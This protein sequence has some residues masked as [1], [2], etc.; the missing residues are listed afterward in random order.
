VGALQLGSCALDH[1]PL[2]DDNLPA[3]VKPTQ[4]DRLLS[5]QEVQKIWH[6]A[7][8]E[9]GRLIKICQL[10]GMRRSEVA[11]IRGDWIQADTLVVPAINATNSWLYSQTRRSANPY[12]ADKGY[13]CTLTVLVVRSTTAHIFHIGDARVSRLNGSSLEQ[14]TEEHRVVVS[15]RESYL[16]RA[17]GVKAQVEIDYWPV[18]IEV[19]DIFFM[20]TDGVHE[21]VGVVD[22][23]RYPALGRRDAASG[24]PPGH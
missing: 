10:T 23:P 17:L 15:S 9:F 20:S 22:Q 1:P 13:V 21:H 19:G 2:A 14:L 7:S 4:R 5:D 18:P 8:G 3:P 16:G 11:A 12:D 24:C 6:A